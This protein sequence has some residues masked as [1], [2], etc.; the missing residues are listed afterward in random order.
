MKETDF[1][2]KNCRSAKKIAQLRQLLKSNDSATFVVEMYIYR[3]KKYF[4]KLYKRCCMFNLL[5]MHFSFLSSS[6][7]KIRYLFC[8][9]R[10]MSRPFCSHVAML[11]TSWD[12]FGRVLCKQTSVAACRFQN[13]Y[14]IKWKLHFVL[15]NL[16]WSEIKLVITNR[17]PASRSCD[18]VITRLI[19]EQIA[20]H[21]VQVN[22]I[23]LS[24]GN[25]I[26][27]I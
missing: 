6:C 7:V 2:T 17:T 8:I 22:C 20:L 13:E 9:T 12:K 3:T 15:C 4:M 25:R 1:P 21:S 14:I 16:F 10:L 24:A 26:M 5:L 11:R 27:V 18:F 23:P 19:S